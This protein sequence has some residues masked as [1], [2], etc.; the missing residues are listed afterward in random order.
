[1]LLLLALLATVTAQ[2]LGTY[3]SPCPASAP[4]AVIQESIISG[5]N[6][7]IDAQCLV[8]TP[9][10]PGYTTC[11]APSVFD[12]FFTDTDVYFRCAESLSATCD[13]GCP[14]QELCISTQILSAPDDAFFFCGVPCAGGFYLCDDTGTSSIPFPSFPLYHLPARELTLHRLLIV[15]RSNEIPQPILYG[16]L[17]PNRRPMRHLLLP[18]PTARRRHLFTKRS[19]FG[20]ASSRER[21]EEECRCAAKRILGRPERNARGDGLSARDEEVCG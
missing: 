10:D 18:F 7:G 2:N 12:A 21:E 13:G 17:R 20:I 5:F 14:E 16:I 19:G 8:S 6:L 9:T 11:P 4:I 1:M 15:A 3:L